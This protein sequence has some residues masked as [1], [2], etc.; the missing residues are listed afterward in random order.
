MLFPEN[1]K[2]AKLM[3]SKLERLPLR[4]V[5]K[6]EAADFTT[7]LQDNL[8]ILNEVLDITVSNAEREK[9]AGAFNVDLVCEDENG[10]PVVI[11]N[12][13]EQSD[14]D[15]LGK[16]ITYLTSL[17][18]KAAIWIVSRPRPEHVGAISWL[19]E[20][21][22]VLFYLVQLE[23]VRIGDSEPAPL[24]TVIV[25]PSPEA[26]A[27]G[28]AKK[29]LSDRHVFRK[30][31]WTGLLEYA[32]EKTKLHANIAPGHWNWI[33]TGAGKAGLSY[34]YSVRQHGTQVELYI[35]TPDKERNKLLFGELVESKEAI[36][37]VFGEPLD[38]QRLEGRKA[39]RIRYILEDGGWKD[40]VWEEAF[41]N[42]VNAMIRLEKAMR[43]HIKSLNG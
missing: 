32:K 28:E 38:W 10:N 9:S 43:P 27:A 11:E 19:N 6:H 12:Q 37:S 29:E 22:S 3:I 20:A 35:D 21:T 31:F 24:F 26:R 23:A 39:C 4:A 14:H 1:E 42:T 5:W 40:E 34:N 17:D 33:G 13:L 25:G 36:E 7:W 2:K 30:R 41:A 15:H 16:L 8:D 18:A